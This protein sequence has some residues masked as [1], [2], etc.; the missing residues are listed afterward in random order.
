MKSKGEK[1]EKFLNQRELKRM[2][3]DGCGLSL[4]K[5]VLVRSF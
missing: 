1:N 3:E 2:W 4:G 5:T